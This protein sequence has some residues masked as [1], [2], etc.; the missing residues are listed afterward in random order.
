MEKMTSKTWQ[1]FERKLLHVIF[2]VPLGNG[3]RS[4]K[5]KIVSFNKFGL[6]GLILDPEWGWKGRSRDPVDLAYS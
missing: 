3:V 4:V 6:K 1:I 2:S 5:F